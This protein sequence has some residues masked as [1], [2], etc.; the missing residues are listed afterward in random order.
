VQPA[1]TPS[2]LL[3]K[4]CA[5]PSHISHWSGSRPR[6][7]SNATSIANT[8]WTASG[9]RVWNSHANFVI[10]TNK[11]PDEHRVAIVS[12]LN[13]AAANSKQIAMSQKR[14]ADACRKT[15]IPVAI[16]ITILSVTSALSAA[17]LG[18]LAIASLIGA[19]LAVYGTGEALTRRRP[20]EALEQC[21]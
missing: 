21:L 10:A 11:M 13:H 19:P 18:T 4:D 1:L 8:I 5:K 17:P 15:S 7:L 12:A 3:F 6:C 2:Q 20:R 9:T 14:N 16:G